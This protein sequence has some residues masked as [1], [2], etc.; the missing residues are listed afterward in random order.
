M[1]FDGVY[2]PVITPF[3]HDG[4]IDRARLAEFTDILIDAGVDGG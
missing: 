3:D 2:V 1:S 4:N